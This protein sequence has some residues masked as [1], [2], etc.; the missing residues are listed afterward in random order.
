MIFFMIL[1]FLL[2]IIQEND[3]TSYRSSTQSDLKST[4]MKI[5][6]KCRFVYFRLQNSSILITAFLSLTKI[7]SF[8]SIAF[9]SF[10]RFKTKEQLLNSS[11][12][13]QDE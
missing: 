8:D 1:I 7:Q 12:L 9:Y 11:N 6:V 13:I 4:S 3:L 5:F 2:K 10:A